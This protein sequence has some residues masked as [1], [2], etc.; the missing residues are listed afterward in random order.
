MLTLEEAIKIAEEKSRPRYK[1]CGEYGEAQ[2]YYV[3][4]AYDVT[5]GLTPPGGFNW[6]VDKETGEFAI[7]GLKRESLRPPWAPIVG[8]KKLGRF[9]DPPKL[10]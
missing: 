10:N 9:P 4:Y 3:F 7:I 6:V 1:L 2:G 8:Y 5:N